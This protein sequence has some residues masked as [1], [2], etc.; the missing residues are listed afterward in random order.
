M[1]NA[2]YFIAGILFTVLISA[3]TISVMTIKPA[4]PKVV[5]ALSCSPEIANGYVN[6]YVSKGYVFKSFSGSD[7][8]GYGLLVMEKY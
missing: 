3:G 6:N 2:V 1:R 5:F 7:K 4:T 8:Y